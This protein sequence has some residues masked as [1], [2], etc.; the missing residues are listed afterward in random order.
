VASRLQI[1][2]FIA[3]HRFSQRSQ[4]IFRFVMEPVE[5]QEPDELLDV[6][7]VRLVGRHQTD[8][9]LACILQAAGALIGRLFCRVGG[10]TLALNQ[11]LFTLVRGLDLALDGVQ[12]GQLQAITGLNRLLPHQIFIDRDRTGNVLAIVT[13]CLFGIE[14]GSQS[15]IHDSCW[16][17]SLLSSG[18]K[19][20]AFAKSSLLFAAA[21]TSCI[22]AGQ[23]AAD[24]IGHR[25]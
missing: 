13:V 25:G 18:S 7:I 6:A 15:T 1:V 16:I 9:L 20:I 4:P 5:C 2:R 12:I 23:G 11:H 10:V 17:S 19:S 24:V 3:D 14:N 22:G 21:A 8:E